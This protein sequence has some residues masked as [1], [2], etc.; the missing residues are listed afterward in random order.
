MCLG[1]RLGFS[2]CAG[3]ACV[4]SKWEH[5]SV[6]RNGG[7]AMLASKTVT[8]MWK[9]RRPTH[10]PPTSRNPRTKGCAVFRPTLARPAV[11]LQPPQPS[12]SVNH[13]SGA[14]GLG[15]GPRTPKNLRAFRRK[16]VSDWR[17]QGPSDEHS[18][19]PCAAL[20]V[21][22]F[23]EHGRSMRAQSLPV[24]HIVRCTSIS[25]PSTGCDAV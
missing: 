19:Q 22:P 10:A 16:I 14:A 1:F 9:S 11:C 12:R 25:S 8:A 21:A 4:T 17:Y 23:P 20:R 2:T 3:F 24:R 18:L 7:P 6:A 13:S 5:S 15:R